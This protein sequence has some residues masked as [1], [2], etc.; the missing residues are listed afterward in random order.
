MVDGGIEFCTPNNSFYTAET[1]AGPKHNRKTHHRGAPLADGKEN[2]AS[3]LQTFSK[4]EASARRPR[5]VATPRAASPPDA[6]SL[7][8]S[9]AFFFDAV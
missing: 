4:T 5:G 6:T 3:A 7:Q 8:N 2:H 1:P 9:A